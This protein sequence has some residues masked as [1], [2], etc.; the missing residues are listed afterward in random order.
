MDPV[1]HALFG[2]A[3]VATVR[4]P[5][6]RSRGLAAAAVLGALSPD[7]D[8]VFMPVGWDIYLRVHSVGTHSLI[9]ALAVAALTGGFVHLLVRSS[10]F[11]L[12]TAAV[13]GALSHLLLDVIC[14]A[15]LQLLWPIST[16][17]FALP[18]VAMA[19]PWLL[20][21]L[22]FATVAFTARRNTASDARRLVAAITLFLAAK[23]AL[24]YV[25]LNQ[26]HTIERGGIA[27]ASMVTARWGS[28]RDWYVFDRTATRL[29]KWRITAL[30]GPATT[31]ISWP[32]P[33]ES[34]LVRASRSLDTVRNFLDV[35]RFA[36]AREQATDLDR[37]LV[38]WSDVR[39]CAVVSGGEGRVAAAASEHLDCQLWVGGVFGRDGRAIAQQ[40]RIGGFVQNRAPP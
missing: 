10:A 14:G 32:L 3:L 31:E 18:L 29:L 40:V 20:G 33:A 22:V 11:A 37:R 8:C 4:T 26:P 24:L 36:F 38:M 5:A 1:S 12:L 19:D 7:I 16:R 35:H 27:A 39:F 2:R 17:E 25:A 23:G 9:G 34:T 30:G 28:L 21:M 15:P 13:A 6:A